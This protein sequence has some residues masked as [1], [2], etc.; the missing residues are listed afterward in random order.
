LNCLTSTTGPGSSDLFD[1]I[2]LAIE[3]RGYI[4]LPTALPAGLTDL[5][6]IHLKSL[7]LESFKQARI[8]RDSREMDNPFVRN[9]K[10]LWLDGEQSA[11]VEYLSWMERLRLAVNRRLFLGLFDY[12][13]HFAYYAKGAFYKKHYDA[14]QGERNRVLTTVYYLNPNWQ[15]LDGGQLQIYSPND[16]GLMESVQPS[17]GQMVIFL[18][19]RFAH[20]VVPAQRERYSLAGW[21]RVNNSLQG[22]IDP[23]A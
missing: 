14:F 18:S 8:G 9:D 13:C 7:S 3:T 10:I 4:I 20:E 17:Y 19:E 6:Y 2:A 11:V 22:R 15:P 23:P 16:G 1:E 12:E 5:L 21:F